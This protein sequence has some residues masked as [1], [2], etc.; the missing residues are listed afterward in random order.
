MHTIPIYTPFNQISLSTG[1]G[2]FKDILARFW[3]A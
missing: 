3:Q 2:Y 1:E